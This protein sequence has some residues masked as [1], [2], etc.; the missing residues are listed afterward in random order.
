MSKKPRILI[1]DDEKSIR[2]ILRDILEY[3]SY[4]VEE[5][6]SGDEALKKVSGGRIDLVILDIKMKGID[7][8]E[9]LEKIKDTEPELPV[10]MI[11]GHG[12]I[13]IA[14]DATKK[15]AYD[16]LEKPPD[17]NRL[18]VTVRNAL[19]SSELIR[20]NKQIKSELLGVSEIIGE[21]APIKKIK[22]TISKIAATSSRVLITGENG[23]GK[24]L[25]A[26]SIH[27]QSR[28][29]SKPFVDVNCAAI[30]S[31]LLESEL[32]GHEKGAFTGAIKQR[33]GK[34]EQANGGTLF[35]DEIGDMS[36][37][38]QAK[39]LRALQENRVTRVGGSESI[40]VDVRVISATN[41]DLRSEIEQGGFREDLYHRLSVIPIHIPPLRERREDIPLLAKTFLARLGEEEIVFSGKSFT[42]D[43]IEVLKEQTWSGNIRELQNVIE[44]LAILSPEDEITGDDVRRLV[45][46]NQSSKKAVSELINDLEKFQ[47][48]KEEAEKLFLVKKLEKYGWNVSATAEAID[49]RR[50]HIYNKMK[51]YDIER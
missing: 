9:T 36:P 51:K 23:T 3:E 42:D 37:D 12:T 17:L 32:F 11:S 6:E 48:F 25:V 8:L 1:T 2:N 28:R 31:E 24:E 41:K 35:L 40:E 13:K 26:R 44:R 4:D 38:A 34:F 21:S 30:P 29:A 15:G 19:K 18:L 14:V 27:S 45:V 10:I 20:E 22:D 7:G 47:D 49:I 5:A 16:F 43:A 50:S 46:G 39:V 33:I